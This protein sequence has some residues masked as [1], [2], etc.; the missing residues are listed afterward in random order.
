[1]TTE[2][3]E[4]REA[5]DEQLNMLGESDDVSAVAGNLVDLYHSHYQQQIKRAELEAQLE[6]I[7]AA[8]ENSIDLPNS[9]SVTRSLASKRR[10]LEEQLSALTSTG[11]E[12]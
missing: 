10:Y 9:V 2:T 8:W 1:M 5:I 12:S 4:L 6:V 7:T 11:D 3:K